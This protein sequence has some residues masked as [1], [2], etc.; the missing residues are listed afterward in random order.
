MNFI[1][2]DLY[3]VLETDV[4]HSLKF[5][6]LPH[7]SGWI[8]RIAEDE[9]CGL[10]IGTFA[11]EVY[12]LYPVLETDVVHSLKFLFLPH[13]SGWI[14]RIAEDEGCGLLIGTFALEVFEIYL[15]SAVAH[16]FQFVFYYFAAA[17]CN[18]G[19]EAVVDRCL[20]QYLFA[21]HADGFQT[22]RNGWYN[23]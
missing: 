23:A 5:L 16:T 8:V 1:G 11:L 7:S 22:A 14:V 10:L 12:D 18:A 13:S 2:N 4:V 6:F 15:I 19:E 9:G 21:R 3:P 20:Y 17:V